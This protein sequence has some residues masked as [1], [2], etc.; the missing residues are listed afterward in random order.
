MKPAEIKS[1]RVSRNSEGKEPPYLYFGVG[2]TA[3]LLK[4]SPATVYNYIKIGKLVSVK[5]NSTLMVSIK[6][7]IVRAC[8]PDLFIEP[9]AAITK[10]K[11]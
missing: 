10:P 3:W 1:I 6:T 7:E 8:W 9:K 2:Q 11:R 4:K 5:V